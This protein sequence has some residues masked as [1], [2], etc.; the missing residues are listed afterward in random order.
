MIWRT[1]L[2]CIAAIPMAAQ[3]FCYEEAGRLYG[4]NPTL[5]KAV[6]IHESAEKPGATHVNT[7][8]TTDYG[9]MQINSWHLPTLSRYGITQRHLLDDAC[10]NAKIGAWVLSG[11]LRRYGQTWESTGAYVA[12]MR[13]EKETA[14]RTAAREIFDIYQKLVN[15]KHS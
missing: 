3:A 6:A 1:L 15:R 11:F 4:V 13:P 9:L 8:G 2:L 14:R 12:G 10:L 7:D 5:L